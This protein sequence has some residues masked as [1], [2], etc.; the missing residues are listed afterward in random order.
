MINQLDF[1]I[2][3]LP[4]MLALAPLVRERDPLMNRGDA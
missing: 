2:C 4:L 3:P 1:S